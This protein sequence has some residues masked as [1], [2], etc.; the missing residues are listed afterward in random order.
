MDTQQSTTL[1]LGRVASPIGELLLVISEGQL[2]AL[3]FAPYEAHLYARLQRRY[4]ALRL[5]PT[6]D[7]CGFEGCLRAYFAGDYASLDALPIDPGGTPFQQQVWHALRGIPAGETRSYKQLAAQLGRPGAARAV[8]AANG[9]NPINIVVPC[10]RLVGA[11]AALRGYRGGMARK[12]W[13]LEHEQ[14]G[15]AISSIC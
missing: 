11:D 12:R 5:V 9:R 3:D 4:G 14:A 2:C 15:A 8:G 1:L 6:D 13:L 7:P 10:H